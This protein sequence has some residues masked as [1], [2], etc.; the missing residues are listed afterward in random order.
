MAKRSWDFM[1][2]IA[3]GVKLVKDRWGCL[4]DFQPFPNSVRLGWLGEREGKKG[5]RSNHLL[6]MCAP[7]VGNLTEGVEGIGRKD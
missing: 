5:F 3:T 7:N 4:L 6:T 2:G 1:P